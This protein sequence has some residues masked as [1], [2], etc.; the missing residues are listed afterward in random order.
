MLIIGCGDIGQR[1]A[2]LAGNHWRVFGVC[3]SPQT[4]DRIRAA[5]AT[6]LLAGVPHRRLQGLARWVVHSAPPPA[7]GV[8]GGGLAIDPLTRAWTVNLLRP[9]GRT[10]HTRQGRHDLYTRHTRHTLHTGP[11]VR[12]ATPVRLV[13]LSTTGV[14]G[15][16]QGRWTSEE[17]AV[18][19]LTE[20]ARRRVDAEQ[21]LRRVGRTSP[22]L[23]PAIL[24]V[25]G[26]YAIDRLPLKRLQERLPALAPVDDVRTNH[27][28]ADDLARLLRVALCR[29]RNQRTLNI[30]DDSSL[31]MGDYLD[32][33]AGWAGLAPPPRVDRPTL[34]ASVTPMR[35]SFMSE[36]R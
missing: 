25:P 36:S 35:A 3:R 14:Y 22:M 23:R 21:C 28:H 34:L 24:R 19:P 26:I 5:G 33:V 10:G 17:T 18:H 27:I 7:D 16:R 4:A 9:P 11:R 2:A 31:A 15:D 30:V 20:R 32:L 1:L 12:P 8:D 13:Y 29:H 6:P